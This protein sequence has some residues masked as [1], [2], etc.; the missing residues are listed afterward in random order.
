MTDLSALLLHGPLDSGTLQIRLNI[1]QATLSRRLA[2]EGDSILKF[3]KARATRYALLRP[4]RGDAVF[5]LWQVDEQGR[6]YAAG[7]L[8]NI[9]PVGSCVICDTQGQWQHYPGLPW[10]IN[11]MRPQGFLGRAWGRELAQQ[12]GLPEDIRLWNDEHSLLALA[13]HGADI[14]GNWLVGEQTYR[15][16]LSTHP[17]AISQQQK[18]TRYPEMAS[19]VLAGEEVGSSVGGEQPKFACYASW[20]GRDAHLLVKFTPARDNE[21]SQRW[22]DLLRAEALALALLRQYG[23]DAAACNLL[24]SASQQLFLEVER[25]D[26]IGIGGRCGLVSLEAVLAEFAGLQASWPVALRELADD[27]VIDEESAQRGTLL[28]AFGRL[29]ANG[30]MHAGNLSFW[31]QS[32]PL[33]L[34]PAY[35][36]LPMSFAPNSAG[37]MRDTVAATELDSRVSQEIWQLAWVI[38]CDYWQ[39][40]AQDQAISAGFRRLAAEMLQQVTQLETQIRRMA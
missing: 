20:Q 31:Y 18:P 39:R 21:N 33:A 32:L 15:Q 13:T 29:I 10:F 8:Y 40:L 22:R 9:W 17:Q 30:D 5:P 23:I 36:M 27:D 4:L 14:G 24:Q 28:W 19:R 34:A 11:D 26:R 6:A 3:G 37:Y 35:D 38:A 12:L 25:F 2:S 1:S 16:W 7:Q